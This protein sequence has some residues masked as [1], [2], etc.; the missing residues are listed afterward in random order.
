MTDRDEWQILISE[1][2]ETVLAQL[3]KDLER[4]TYGLDGSIQLI[5]GYSQL[6]DAERDKVVTIMTNWIHRQSNILEA[7]RNYVRQRF[8]EQFKQWVSNE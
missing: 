8:P 2:P 5:L 3:L 6:T 4:P 7:Y 1:P